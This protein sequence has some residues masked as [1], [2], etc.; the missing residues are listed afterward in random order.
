MAQYIAK[1][2]ARELAWVLEEDEHGAVK[3]VLWDILAGELHDAECSM[4]FEGT[5]L[6]LEGRGRPADFEHRARTFRFWLRLKNGCFR[7]ERESP[8]P[9]EKIWLLS[10]EESEHG[11]TLTAQ[12]DTLSGLL[13]FSGD[14]FEFCLWEHSLGAPKQSEP[15]D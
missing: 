12:D 9:I 7:D 5:D 14:D 8:L 13:R 2:L 11:F 1:A 4:R 15:A 10:K 6:V 3:Q